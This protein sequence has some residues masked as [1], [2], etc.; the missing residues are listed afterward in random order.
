MAQQQQRGIRQNRKPR[1]HP[2]GDGEV[3]KNPGSHLPKPP[4]RRGDCKGGKGVLEDVQPGLQVETLRSE[5]EAL[6]DQLATYK[7]RYAEAVS[8]INRAAAVKFKPASF[9]PRPKLKGDFVEVIVSDIHGNKHDPAAFA[10]FESDLKS[11]KPNRVFLGGDIMDCGG[12]LA[13]HHTLGYV[14]ETEDSYEEDLAATNDILNRIQKAAPN[15]GVHYLEGN[16]ECLHP[17]HEVLT[18]KGW[19]PISDVGLDDSVAAM[20]E[21]GKTVWEHPYRTMSYLFDGSMVRLKGRAAEAFMTPNHRVAYWGTYN[22]DLRYRRADSMQGET[23]AHIPTSATPSTIDFADF[24]DDDIRLTAWI[25]TDGHINGGIGISQSKLPTIELISQLLKRMG[26]DHRHSSRDRE[27]KDIC[28]VA[29]KTVKTAHSFTFSVAAGRLVV[30]RL[31]GIKDWHRNG[32]YTKRIPSWVASLSERQFDIFLDTLVLGD[33]SN[34]S[35]GQQSRCMYGRFDFLSDLQGYCVTHGHRAS[36]VQRTRKGIKD[37]WVLNLTKRKLTRTDGS[38]YSQEQYSGPVFCLSM[39]SGNFFTRYN[40]RV[41]VT[42]N[43]RVERW[44]LTQRLAHHKDVEMLRRTFCAEHRLGLEER[45]ITYYQQGIVHPGCSVQGWVHLDNLFYVHKIS[46]AVDAGRV[47]VNKTGGN[48][49]FFDTHRS[50]FSPKKMPAAGLIAAWNPGCLCK[51]QPLWCNT[52]PTGWTH[53]YLVRFISRTG[54]FQMVN[55]SI[56]EG[57]SFGKTMFN[58]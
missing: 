42:G 17:G 36:L 5:V 8:T 28:G 32:R 58:H 18:S 46:N 25:L 22:N 7:H 52:N 30:G 35:T 31:L 11:I 20:S 6:R 51:L 19:K 21:S 3:H 47:A 12:F 4:R 53:G 23:M 1:V 38:N 26:I 56:E 40:G 49:V 41:H 15:A 9:K 48:L 45:G 37:Y 50:A 39:P 33:G 14:A 29:V 16:H 2:G 57:V 43:S 24:T 27:K 55:I 10:A 34:A 54:L 44:A 13:E